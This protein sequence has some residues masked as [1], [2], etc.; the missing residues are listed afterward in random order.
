MDDHKIYFGGGDLISMLE[1]T[2]QGVRDGSIV[3]VA[4]CVVAPHGTGWGGRVIEG[5]PHGWA[6]M[7]ASM[8]DAQREAL[9]SP[10]AE[11]PVEDGR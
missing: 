3:G 7:V 2:I 11:W 6:R 1:E 10:I 5:T 8:A 9:A 4:V